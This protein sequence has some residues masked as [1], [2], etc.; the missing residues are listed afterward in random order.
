M[1]RK[2]EKLNRGCLN[3]FLEYLLDEVLVCSGNLDLININKWIN[4]FLLYGNNF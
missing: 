3:V 2:L 4:N 1:I